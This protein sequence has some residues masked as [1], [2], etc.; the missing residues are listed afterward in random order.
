MTGNFRVSVTDSAGVV[1]ETLDIDLTTLAPPNIGQ[2]VT[3]IDAMANA[4]AS[5]NASGQ[6]T[7]AGTGGN[8]IA[9]NELD[10]LVA[11]GNRPAAWATSWA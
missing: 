3:Q 4:T 5:L 1:V 7:I 6:V 8:R 9:V 11:T 2:L 10:S